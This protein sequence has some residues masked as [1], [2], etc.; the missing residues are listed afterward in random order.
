MTAQNPIRLLLMGSMPSQ[1]LAQRRDDS[2]DAEPTLGQPTLLPGITVTH[3]GRNKMAAIFQTTF[4]NA[5]SWMKIYQFRWRF[6]WNLFPRVQLT[7]FQ[8]WFR[9]WLGAG[10]ATSHY[11]NQWWLVYWRIYASLGL[12][13]LTSYERG[14]VNRWQ[15]DLLVHR[16]CPIATS[17]ISRTLVCNKTVDHS[18]VV[19]PPPVGAAPTT[20]SF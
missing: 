13:E 5:F 15:L 7:I 3:W 4:W 2:T 12:N 6:H 14:G 16:I 20:S 19:G 1:T 10:Q 11:L 9:Q 18:D 17:N 8:H